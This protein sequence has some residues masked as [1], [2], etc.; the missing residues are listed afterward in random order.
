MIISLNMIKDNPFY[1]V[2]KKL[3]KIF[4]KFVSKTNHK[5]AGRPKKYSDLQIIQCLMY[6]VMKKI[7]CLRELE[8]ELSN[9]A[10]AIKIIGLTDIP[11]HSTFSIRIKQIEDSL[12]YQIYR[13]FVL[14]LN[15]DLRVC[16]ID[17][18]ALRSSK[19]D[20]EAKKGK[21]TRL[22]WYKGYKLHL[23]SS[24]DSIP[25]A[26]NFTTA[27]VYDS[28]CKKLIKEL[29]DYDIFVLLGDAAYDSVKLFELCDELSINLLTD[30][31]LRK[32]KSIDSIKNEYRKKNVLYLQSPIGEKVY[33]KRIT[34]ERLFAV[35]KQRYNLENPRLYGHTRYKSHVMWTLLLYLIEKL[36]D[37]EKGVNSLKFPWNK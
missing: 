11:D 12:F 23:V 3:Q 35:L 22:G 34:I 8:W 17:S 37:Q 32:A 9:D 25:I 5:K 7:C 19:F 24:S 27:N 15:P 2:C 4:D 28:N 30:I 21:S 20:S 1:K 6:K 10:L 31:N 29:D 18:T 16:S 14:L 36:I 13:L 26:F 33:K